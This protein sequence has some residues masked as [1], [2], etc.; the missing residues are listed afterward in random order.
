MV[1][2]AG[3]YVRLVLKTVDHVKGLFGMAEFAV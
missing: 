1:G 2:E 3:G